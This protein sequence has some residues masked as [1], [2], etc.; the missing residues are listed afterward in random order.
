MMLPLKVELILR[1]DHSTKVELILQH[2][3]FQVEDEMCH[4]AIT[5]QELEG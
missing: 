4:N 5:E 3:S 1:T 2:R